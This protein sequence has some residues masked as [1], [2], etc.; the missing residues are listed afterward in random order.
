[1]GLSSAEKAIFFFYQ[2]DKF[3][4]DKVQCF[5]CD[6]PFRIFFLPLS[7]PFPQPL[8]SRY[9]LRFMFFLAAIKSWVLILGKA[10]KWE[11]DHL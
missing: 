7:F 3:P 9:L 2:K 4:K 6:Y 8:Y 1:M 11:L 10:L 5:F